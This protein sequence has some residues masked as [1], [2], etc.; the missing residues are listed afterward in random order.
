MLNRSS[1]LLETLKWFK[2]NKMKSNPYYKSSLL[3]SAKEDREKFWKRS[4]QKLATRRLATFSD[5]FD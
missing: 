1:K 5:V 3:L 2:D 4:H